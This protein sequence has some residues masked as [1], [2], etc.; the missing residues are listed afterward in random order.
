M[1]S[2]SVWNRS[3]FNIGNFKI[4]KHQ[5]YRTYT[6]TIPISISLNDDD[7]ADLLFRQVK[8]IIYIGTKKEYTYIYFLF[9]A[10][11]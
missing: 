1:T 7:I 4:T 8:N 5:G 6:S 9:S 3:K 2:A 10:L 11:Y